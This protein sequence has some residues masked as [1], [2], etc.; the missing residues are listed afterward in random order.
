MYLS[1]RLEIKILYKFIIKFC[2]P[3]VYIEEFF[4]DFYIRVVEKLIFIC[5]IE[6]VD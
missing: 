5:F 6:T 2:G 1:Q 3:R 4:S